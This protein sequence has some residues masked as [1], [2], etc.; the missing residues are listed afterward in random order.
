RL[1]P[2]D[3]VGEG[4]ARDP[5]RG[6]EAQSE[7]VR[8][9]HG[10]RYREHAPATTSSVNGRPAATL[11]VVLIH[12]AATSSAIFLDAARRLGHERRVLAPD[13]PGP[14]GIAGPSLDLPDPPPDPSSNP[15]TIAAYRDAVGAFCA[16]LC[17]E[18]AILV[19]HSM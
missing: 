13:L 10:T 3:D 16:A 9:A 11:P 8:T 7:P 4:R 17:L 2:R 5:R 12:G 1:R 14:R 19:G 18:R 15:P 6:E